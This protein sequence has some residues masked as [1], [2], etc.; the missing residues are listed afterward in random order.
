MTET[1]FVLLEFYGVGPRYSLTVLAERLPQS[2]VQVWD[3]L[4][5]RVQSAGSLVTL[6]ADLVTANPVSAGPVV[7]IGSCFGAPLVTACATALHRADPVVALSIDPITVDDG[8]LRA[9]VA[10]LGAHP[11]VSATGWV[12][13]VVRE[14][15]DH[16]VRRA[17]DEGDDLVE[18]EEAADHLARH[19]RLWLHYLRLCRQDQATTRVAQAVFSEAG[20]AGAGVVRDVLQLGSFADTPDVLASDELADWAL[21][22]G[23]R[24]A[25]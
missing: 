1:R 7:L 5:D 15:R 10:A 13:H 2:R 18:A 23:D 6:A 3:V 12:E 9:Q 21:R 22:A 16:A 8:V 25:G 19:Y 24:S 20:R 11:D 17:V 14:L 4:I